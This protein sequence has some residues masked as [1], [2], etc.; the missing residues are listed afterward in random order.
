MDAARVEQAKGML[1]RWAAGHAPGAGVAGM[2]DAEMEQ[3]IELVNELA[4]D[5]ELLTALTAEVV[6]E[7]ATMN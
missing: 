7:L 1:R 3:E 2:T 6:A 4:A 5:K